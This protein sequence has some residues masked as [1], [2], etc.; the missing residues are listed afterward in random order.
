MP[1]NQ[2][3]AANTSKA[4]PMFYVLPHLILRPAPWFRYYEISILQRKT[5]KAKKYWITCPRSRTEQG[6]SPHLH[7]ILQQLWPARRGHLACP[8]SLWSQSH[9]HLGHSSPLGQWGC[10]RWYR[11]GEPWVAKFTGCTQ[12][13]TLSIFVYV[14]YPKSANL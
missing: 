3:C 7:L 14:N 9:T 1:P 4:I 8:A 11:K 13:H 2:E 5:T 10:E 6:A 12:G